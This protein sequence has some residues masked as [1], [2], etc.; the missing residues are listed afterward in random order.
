LNAWINNFSGFNSLRGYYN[1][2]LAQ[3]NSDHYEIEIS[4]IQDP[5]IEILMSEE[6][7]LRIADTIYSYN[8]SLTF[9]NLFL[10]EDD[11]KADTAF[12][13]K[14][15]SICPCGENTRC[16]Y[17]NVRDQK[18][19]NIKK[20]GAKWVYNIGIA[21]SVGFKSKLQAR[22]TSA[23][24]WKNYKDWQMNT[25]IDQYY[26]LRY[27]DLHPNQGGSSSNPRILSNHRH[28]TVA[29]G[30]NNLVNESSYDVYTYKQPGLIGLHF[31]CVE[32]FGRTHN[33][34]ANNPNAGLHPYWE[35]DAHNDDW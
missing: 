20:L 11:I 8:D 22:E 16:N 4:R 33:W 31:I 25:F 10:V 17:I 15:L 27:W 14:R 6:Y 29:S 34:N 12:A 28:K 24:K 30:E 23:H 26:E 32:E 3:N 7:E 1:D 19:G 9:L 5:Y 18:Y 35:T 13:T 21:G 2:L